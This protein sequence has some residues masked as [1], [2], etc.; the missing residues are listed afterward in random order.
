MENR[1]TFLALAAALLPIGVDAQNA[2]A[3]PRPGGDI[4]R[5]ALAGP[6][7]GYEAVLSD[8]TLPPGRPVAASPAHRHSGFVLGCVIEGKLRFAI[9]NEPERI[10]PTGGTFFEPIGALHSANGAAS[11]GP[12]RFLAFLVVPKG[13]PV[14]VPA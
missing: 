3:P 4:A 6:F 9:N 1:R 12:V 10:V 7:E 13:S 14:V 2:A 11:D 8:V 5:H